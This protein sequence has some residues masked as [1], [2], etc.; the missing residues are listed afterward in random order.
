[1]SIKLFSLYKLLLWL[2]EKRIYNYMGELKELGE[3]KE[4]KPLDV[5]VDTSSSFY[6]MEMGFQIMQNHMNKHSIYLEQVHVWWLISK[7]CPSLISR[8]SSGT[9][10]DLTYKKSWEEIHCSPSKWKSG[11]IDHEWTQEYVNFDLCW[12]GTKEEWTR[13]FSGK[14]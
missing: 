6:G 13:Y 4:F 9:M 12:K 5:I 3:S 8:Q 7:H 2:V 11:Q 10:M 1:M 14:G